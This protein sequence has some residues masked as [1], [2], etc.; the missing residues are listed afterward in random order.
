MI[1]AGSATGPRGQALVDPEIDIHEIVMGLH[2]DPPGESGHADAADMDAMCVLF[3]RRRRML[4]VVHAGRPRNENGSV[5][6]TGDSRLG[7]SEWDDERI[8]VFLPAL[9]Q[10]VAAVAFVVA[11][12]GGRTF[13]SIR[14]ACCHVSDRASERAWMRVD[15]TT[16]ERHTVHA[17]AA[18]ARSSAGWR[19]A[20][21]Q[22]FV[23]SEL[24]AELLALAGNIKLGT[25][26]R[27][28]G[29][30]G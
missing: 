15:L 6:H 24:L 10:R 20:P 23:G 9:P 21:P 7:A 29:R 26:S 8:F 27:C 3:D 1:D 28:P 30:A 13:G 22:D 25:L 17:V 2:W 12:A 18:L 14:G 4:E 19:F 5:V 11:S 16:L